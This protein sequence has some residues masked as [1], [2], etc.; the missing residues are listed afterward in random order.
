MPLPQ[1]GLR[2]PP[3]PE[4]RGRFVLLKYCVL[5]MGGSLVLDLVVGFLMAKPIEMILGSLSP[6]MDLVAGIF[7]LSDD[8]TIAPAHH[9]LV[10]TFC[11]YCAEQN[12]CSGGMSCLLPFV[13]LNAFTVV[14]D[15]LFDGVLGVIV[16][17]IQVVLSGVQDET[18]NDPNLP[19]FKFAIALHVVSMLIAL[20]AKSIAVYVGF[21][22]FQESN[23][24]SSV[25]PG[26]WGNNQGAGSWAGGQGGQIGQVAQGR[27]AETPQE[28]RPAAGFQVFSGEGNVLG[29]GP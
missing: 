19:T 27:P 3:P 10:T 14:W 4:L 12:D 7:L 22:A 5:C 24:G 1:N 21:K 18:T 17:G 29:P 26:T 23:S 13:F 11:Q 16:N 20:I 2:G 8:L 6:I 25:I 15:V 28:A 9:C